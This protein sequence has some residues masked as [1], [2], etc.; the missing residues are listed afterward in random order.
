MHDHARRH[1]RKLG[2]Q[3]TNRRLDRVHDRPLRRPLIPRRLMAGQRLLHRVLRDPQ[4]SGDSP[5]S[6]PLRPVQPADLRPVLH[7]QHLMIVM[8]WV[9]AH[10]EPDGQSSAGNDTAVDLIAWTQLLVLRGHLAKAEPKTL[11]YRL[12]HVAARLTRGQRRRIQRSCA[13]GPRS[14]RRIRP[15]SPRCPSRPVEQHTPT[16]QTEG[17]TGRTAGR[18]PRHAHPRPTHQPRPTGP[19]EDR[20]GP[21]VNHRG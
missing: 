17:A 10:T 15:G 5:D 3:H 18:A 12:L 1:V 4:P 6:H 8:G 14:V 13:L 2:Q 20:L 16:R 9:T 21:S 19:P 11:R 7:V